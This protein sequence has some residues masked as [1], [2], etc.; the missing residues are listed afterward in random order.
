M[1][2]FKGIAR[3]FKGNAQMVK[4]AM[5][6]LGRRLIEKVKAHVWKND[7]GILPNAPATIEKKGGDTPMI[8]TQ[9][10]I[11]QVDYKIAKLKDVK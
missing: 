7:V 4:I 9:H 5:R 10:M 2:K 11:R 8:D 3:L 1:E 6:E